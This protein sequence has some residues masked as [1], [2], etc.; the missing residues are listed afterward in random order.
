MFEKSSSLYYVIYYLA[1]L[2]HDSYGLECYDCTSPTNTGNCT[3]NSF[4]SSG[5][6]TKTC[7][8]VNNACSVKS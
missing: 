2:V 1:V 8:G 4:S 3:E 6:T 5:I 7:D